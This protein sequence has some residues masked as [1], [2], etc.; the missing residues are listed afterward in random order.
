MRSNTLAFMQNLDRGG[1]GTHFHNFVHQMVGHALEVGIKGQMV[2]NVYL[3]AR[4]LAHIEA[5]HGQRAQRRP[6]H[7]GEHRAAR[8]FA[9]AER[10]VI[11]LFEQP[12]DLSIHLLQPKELM[13]TQSGDDPP[14]NDLY[15]A[16]CGELL[17]MSGSNFPQLP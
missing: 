17:G 4:P 9:F 10:F 15:A 7:G 8:A 1:S 3:R 14:L 6:V 13:M 5:L 11:Q 16:F 12:R 2:I